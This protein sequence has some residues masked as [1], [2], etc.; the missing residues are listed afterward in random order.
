MTSR[1]PALIRGLA[2]ATGIFAAGFF[3]A[4]SATEEVPNC[5][6][7]LELHCGDRES[8]IFKVKVG[9]DWKVAEILPE[10]R[11][12]RADAAANCLLQHP[13]RLADEVDMHKRHGADAPLELTWT[14]GPPRC[15]IR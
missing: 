1:H 9:A 12:P 15:E 13:G 14:I 6:K 3:H 5:I 8:Y 10:S 2:L 7:L 4:A 11:D